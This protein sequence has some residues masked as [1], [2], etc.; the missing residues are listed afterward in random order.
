MGR[1][2]EDARPNFSQQP[3]APAPV[4]KTRPAVSRHVHPIPLLMKTH[5]SSPFLSHEAIAQRARR[6]WENR[7]QPSGD[8]VEIWLEAETQL[9]AEA[10]SARTTSAAHQPAPAD[11]QPARGTR[12][13]SSAIRD[14]IDPEAVQE[15]LD[16]FGEPPRRSATSAE[17]T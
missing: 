1:R 7:G 13:A 3:T 11:V 16:D 2:T 8:D 4:A 17:V 6:I 10:A 5:P 9:A 14:D 12:R 15:R